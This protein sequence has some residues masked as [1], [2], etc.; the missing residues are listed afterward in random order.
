M[1][2]LKHDTHSLGLWRAF[3][4]VFDK[5]NYERQQREQPIPTIPIGDHYVTVYHDG[6]AVDAFN[7]RH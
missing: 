6:Q 7:E 4:F 5:N 1:E 3:R 2:S